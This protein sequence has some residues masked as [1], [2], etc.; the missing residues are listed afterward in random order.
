MLTC[1]QQLTKQ[2][3]ETQRRGQ[4]GNDH[5]HVGMVKTE[6]EIELGLMMRVQK[7]QNDN[8]GTG[9]MKQNLG[10]IADKNKPNNKHK[11]LHKITKTKSSEQ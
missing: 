1:Q 8:M 2:L 11:R 5:M 9:V 3:E 7:G 10:V 6:K 4:T